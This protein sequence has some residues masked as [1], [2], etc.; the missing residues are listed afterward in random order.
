MRRFIVMALVM[1]LG[2]TACGK[3]PDAM[4]LAPQNDFVDRDELETG[5]G[6]YGA[7]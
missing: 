7:V 4:K 3:D 6:R 5:I 2:L 1:L